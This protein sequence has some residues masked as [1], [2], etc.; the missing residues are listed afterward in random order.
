MSIKFINHRFFLVPFLTGIFLVTALITPTA[1]V[2][3]ISRTAKRPKGAQEAKVSTH[4]GLCGYMLT[5]AASPDLIC[6]GCFPF[7][8]QLISGL[9]INHSN[10]WF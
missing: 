1:T 3:R 2:W 5:M 9:S 8:V 4:I 6:F 10:Q 7:L